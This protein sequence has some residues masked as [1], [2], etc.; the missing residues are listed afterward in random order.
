MVMTMAELCTLIGTQLFCFQQNS[1]ALY[2]HGESHP[3]D[4][5]G[6]R[7]TQPQNDTRR[8]LKK[9]VEISPRKNKTNDKLREKTHPGVFLFFSDE[10]RK[11][12]N[13]EKEN[14]GGGK[15]KDGHTIVRLTEFSN[16]HRNMA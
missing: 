8:F 1:F 16:P 3:A 9:S 4:T 11:R 10:N 15:G 7:K 5:N 12:T 2:K 6:N 13:Q 14:Q